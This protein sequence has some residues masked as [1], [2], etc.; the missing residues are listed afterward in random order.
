M[1]AMVTG[2]VVPL[3]I[4]AATSAPAGA[5]TVATVSNASGNPLSSLET[6]LAQ[7]SASVASTVD[8]LVSQL[9]GDTHNLEV[10]LQALLAA[11]GHAG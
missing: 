4:A 8:K 9:A 3:S 1:G 6:A 5:A 10:Q 7:I 11:L 2:T